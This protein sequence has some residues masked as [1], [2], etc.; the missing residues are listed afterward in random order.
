LKKGIIPG[1]L[2]LTVALAAIAEQGSAPSVRQDGN[3][4]HIQAS[5]AFLRSVPEGQPIRLTLADPRLGTTSI[6][7]APRRKQKNGLAVTTNS[8]L[9][10]LPERGTLVI[11]SAPSAD[12]ASCVPPEFGADCVGSFC[13]GTTYCVPGDG[14]GG[15]VCSCE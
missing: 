14:P 1:A 13:V 11:L 10:F 9:T 8:S 2:V 6:V 3:L 12:P 15:F 7:G 5:Q 4:V